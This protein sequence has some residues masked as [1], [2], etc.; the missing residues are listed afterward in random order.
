MRAWV[1]LEKFQRTVEKTTCGI[2]AGIIL[3][4]VFPVSIDVVLRYL[5]RSPIPQVYDLSEFMIVGAAYLAIAYVQAIKGHIKIEAATARLPEKWKIVLDIFG[6]GLGAGLFAIITWQ[7][8]RLAWEAWVTQDHTMGVINLPLWPAKSIVPIGT[9]LLCLRL[10]SDIIWEI[11]KL[12]GIVLEDHSMN[13]EA[14]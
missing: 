2:A 5:F 14:K 8:A 9:A 12:R 10:I 7:S 1:A 13:E 6:Y 11:G 4:M 3:F